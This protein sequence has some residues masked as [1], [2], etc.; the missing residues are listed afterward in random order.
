M[1]IRR[2]SNPDLDTHKSG[3]FL[4]QWHKKLGSD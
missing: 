3:I 2:L 1:L 4:Y